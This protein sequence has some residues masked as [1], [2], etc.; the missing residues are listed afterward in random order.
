MDRIYSLNE[1][2]TMLHPIFDAYG[3]RR[4]ILFGSYAKGEAT[5]RSDVDLVIDCN[6]RG[7]KFYGVIH[8][9]ESVLQ[10]ECDVFRTSSIAA[11]SQISKEIEK[12]GVVIYE[13]A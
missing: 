8:A 10:K 13:N 2:Q 7:L 3:V 6:Q 5:D 4:A 1:I 9:I 11:D 12:T